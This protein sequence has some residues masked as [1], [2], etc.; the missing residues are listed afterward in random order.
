[1][2]VTGGIGIREIRA[3]LGIFS[4]EIAGEGKR[5]EKDERNATEN[6]EDRHRVTQT[7]AELT[8]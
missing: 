4:V 5:K 6:G 2:P 7:N 3:G 8:T 1:M